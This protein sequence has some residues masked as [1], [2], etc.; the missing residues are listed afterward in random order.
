MQNKLRKLKSNNPKEFW[1]NIHSLENKHEKQNINIETLYDFFKG[2]NE[3][4][5]HDNDDHDIN[6]DV[7]DDDEILN[8][9]ITEAEILKYLKS[10]KNNKCPTNDNINNEYLKNSTEKMLPIYISL[11]NLILDTGIIP[12]SWLEGVIRP[13][14]K[15]NGEP[16][17][18]E[19]YRPITILSCFGKLFTAIL[20]LRLNNFLQ[21]YNILE[22]NQAGFRAGYSTTD[23]IFTLHALTEILKMK[24]KKLFC[25][26]IDFS[27]AF[28]SVWRIGLWMKLLG[29]GIQ[30]KIFKVIYNLYRNSKSCVSHY[31]EQSAF[32]QSYCGVRQG[33]NLSPVLFSLF[34]NDLEEYMR[35]L[36][37][38]GISLN[39]PGYD[40]DT[41]LKI[42]V[43]LYADDTVV[44]GTDA[45]SFQHNLNVFY[46]YTQQW[47]PN[48]NFRKT[49]I[50][51]FGVRNTNNFQFK[52]GNNTIDICD[53]LK[54]LG[55]VFTKHRSFFKAIKHNT[56]QAKKALQLMYKRINNLHIPIDLQIHL[57]DH[58]ILPILL[59]GCET[60]GFQNTKLLENV[61]NQFLRNIT[62]LRK[63]TPVYMLHA[64]LGR[65]PI[66]IQIKSRM[67]N[68][69]IT[70]VNGDN[71]N[72]LSKI[73]YNI[74]L[75]ETNN[76]HSFKWLDNIKNILISVGKPDLINQPH[77]N[78]PHATKLKIVS[79]LNDLA[80]QDWYGKLN[81]SSKGRNYNLY[82]NNMNIEPY[83]TSLPK[84]LY[85]PLIKFR[86]S[87]YKLPIETGRWEN[88]NIEDRKCQLCYKNDLGDDFHYLLTCSYF[89]HDRKNYIKPYFYTRPNIIKYKK[90][91]DKQ[92]YKTT[93][94]FIKVYEYNNEQVCLIKIR[95]EPF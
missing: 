10:L 15:R 44:F 78:N 63:S 28:D 59:Y 51:I 57:F 47:K 90:I 88:I 41:Y 21:F 27:K 39:T 25:S 82:K 45:D 38:N 94:K 79:A 52:L 35:N 58:T 36:N 31:G 24:N 18:P 46:D 43:L 3:N 73:M 54:Y 92:E 89:D 67:I 60:W 26:F 83:L 37:C 22:E 81:Q 77:I 34:L 95:N 62:K 13:I 5:E 14:Y 29:N 71:T 2:L 50:L 30:G 91:N 69:W 85:I 65:V 48:I 19:N 87:N 23:Y 42:L 20:N 61:H 7:T 76:G 8:S 72:K 93:D 9:S 53:E 1:K 75:D 6:I 64:E 49:K 68:Y 80:V 12:D 86:T 33:E 66:E 40:I 11:F 55:V 70:L 17:Q 74:M 32:F 4:N 84:L 16:Q 56:V